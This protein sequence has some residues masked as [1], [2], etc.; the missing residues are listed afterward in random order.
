MYGICSFLKIKKKTKKEKIYIFLEIYSEIEIGCMYMEIKRD[1][2]DFTLSHT[3]IG[4]CACSRAHELR[5]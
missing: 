4:F 2:K 5:P 1:E 3:D